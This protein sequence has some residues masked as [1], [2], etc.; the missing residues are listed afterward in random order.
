MCQYG[1]ILERTRHDPNN[2]IIE[3]GVG[4]IECF[5]NKHESVGFAIVDVEDLERCKQ[6]KWHFE[7]NYVLC[8]ATKW[9]LHHF[10]LNH[11]PSKANVVDHIN[12]NGLDNRKSNLRLCSIAQNNCNSARGKNNSSGYVGVCYN[13]K[14]GKWVASITKNYKYYTLGSFPTKELAGAAYN[15][16]AK[17]LHGEFA[18]VNIIRRKP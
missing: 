18:H 13:K 14:T 3:D 9:Y 16:A 7:R 11:K 1:K 6:H 12:K 8:T 17:E 4:K 2:F 15:K 5:N 10:I